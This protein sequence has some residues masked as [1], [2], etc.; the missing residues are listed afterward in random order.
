M[1]NFTCQTCKVVAFH[2]YT[3]LTQ[4][5]AAVPNGIKCHMLFMNI[6]MYVGMGGI[7]FPALWLESGVCMN[8]DN[9][10]EPVILL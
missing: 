10:N 6:D 1:A 4:L 3:C 9:F 8:G 5:I 2:V 7:I